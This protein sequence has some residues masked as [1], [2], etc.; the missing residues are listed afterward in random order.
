MT[1]PS[2]FKN[3]FHESFPFEI[4]LELCLQNS[5]HQGNRGRELCGMRR[6]LVWCEFI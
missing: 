3:T 4:I 5:N 2:L 6:L 1:D